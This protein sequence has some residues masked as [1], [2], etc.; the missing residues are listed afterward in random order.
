M[1]TTKFEAESSGMRNVDAANCAQYLKISVFILI[2][3]LCFLITTR[4]Y[5]KTQDW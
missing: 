4:A 1:E 2:K 3:T 5:I